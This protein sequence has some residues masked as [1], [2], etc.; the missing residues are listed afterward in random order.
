MKDFVGFDSINVFL[1]YIICKPI[2]KHCRAFNRIVFQ[3]NI[4]TYNITDYIIA[5]LVF[6]YQI[7]YS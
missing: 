1:E 3:I 6:N 4:Q 2:Y 7:T 5:S